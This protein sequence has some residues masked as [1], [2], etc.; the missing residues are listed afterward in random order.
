MLRSA[1]PDD[2]RAMAAWLRE[3]VR[4]VA[5]LSFLTV[6]GSAIAPQLRVRPG[7]ARHTRKG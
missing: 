1:F 4:P 7:H 5:S 3:P 2:G 6:A